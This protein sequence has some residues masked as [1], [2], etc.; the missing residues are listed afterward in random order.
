MRIMSDQMTPGPALHIRPAQAQN[1]LTKAL[2]KTPGFV[3]G[4]IGA[5]LGLVLAL[6][7]G[8][9]LLGLQ[10]PMNRIIDAYAR[11]IEITTTSAASTSV[12]LETA[13]RRATEAAVGLERVNQLVSKLVA[14][15]DTLSIR[16]NSVSGRV[17]GIENRVNQLERRTDV[18]FDAQGQP[19]PSRRSR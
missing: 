13:S 12:A 7:A 6:A 1:F 8:V 18:L 17:D 5:G 15:V 16:L 11:Q 10:G 3:L 19:P 4:F 14:D 2:E 9:M